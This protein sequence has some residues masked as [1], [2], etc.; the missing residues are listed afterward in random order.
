M[1]EITHE[2]VESFRR[3]WH[4]AN[5]KVFGE[6]TPGEHATIDALIDAWERKHE[7]CKWTYTNE[8]CWQTECGR[9]WV[10]PAGDIETNGAYF[11]FHC[12][13]RIEEV[14]GE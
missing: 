7:T 3:Y 11:C 5:E 13:R 9:K 6:P 1:R 2:Q 4:V 12:G 14:Q 8:D 10:F